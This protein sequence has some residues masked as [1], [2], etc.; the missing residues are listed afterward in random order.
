[1]HFPL[2]DSLSRARLGFDLPDLVKLHA[3]GLPI[4]FLTP[5]QKAQVFLDLAVLSW[6]FLIKNVRCSVKCVKGSELFFCLILVA[7][8]LHVV[9]LT[10]ISVS[11]CLA[12]FQGS[13]ALR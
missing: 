2:R 11:Y 10:L 7:D 4:L 13:I 8:A 12:R 6:W 9:L 1:L 5:D 3:E